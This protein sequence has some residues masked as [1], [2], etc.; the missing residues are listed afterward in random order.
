MKKMLWLLLAFSLILTIGSCK[1]VCEDDT[2]YT[3][4]DFNAVPQRAKYSEPETIEDLANIIIY[5]EDLVSE[6]ES[7]G[8]SVY[9][10][11]EIPLP[12]RL[13]SVKDYIEKQSDLNP[14]LD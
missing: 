6:W 10:M 5:Y 13:Q 1:T 4:E 11:L 8:I 12:A 9:D 2:E 3:A 7:W 14:I